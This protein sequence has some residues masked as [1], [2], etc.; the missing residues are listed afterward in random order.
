MTEKTRQ[1]VMTGYN[2]PESLSPNELRALRGREPYQGKE[3]DPLRPDADLVTMGPPA[4]T[5]CGLPIHFVDSLSPFRSEES[6]PPVL[7]PRWIIDAIGPT[8]QCCRLGE[9]GVRCY[10]RSVYKATWEEQGGT[11]CTY[12][13]A[14]HLGSVR[15]DRGPV[16]V[17][18]L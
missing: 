8:G 7:N 14:E 6:S 16:A 18:E 5:L 10:K 1:A 2:C 9:D 15:H 17:E 11:D 12:V 4:A 3:S 13:C